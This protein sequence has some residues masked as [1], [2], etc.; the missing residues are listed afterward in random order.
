MSDRMGVMKQIQRRTSTHD[1]ASCTKPAYC[2]MEDGKS[3][4]LCWCMFEE[5]T[6]NPDVDYTNC[7]CRECLRDKG[8]EGEN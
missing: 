3:S 6:I 7:L 4:T 2:A 8:M 1:C 5:R